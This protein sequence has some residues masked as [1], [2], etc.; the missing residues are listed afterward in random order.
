M[1]K[2]CLEG[3]TRPQRENWM[4]GLDLGG[5]IEELLTRESDDRPGN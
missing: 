2:V 5:L 3:E 4:A 1:R